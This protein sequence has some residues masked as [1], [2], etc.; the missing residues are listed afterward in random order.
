MASKYEC[1]VIFLCVAICCDYLLLMWFQETIK[2]T[3]GNLYLR[4]NLLL[5]ML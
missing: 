4:I 5:V 3:N 1:D 2:K